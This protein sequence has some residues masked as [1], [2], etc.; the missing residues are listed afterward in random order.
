MLAVSTAV[1]E[2]E[3]AIAAHCLDEL[4]R[5]HRA[6]VLFLG[7]WECRLEVLVSLV[8]LPD[9]EGFDAASHLIARLAV[10]DGGV[11]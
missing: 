10:D 2:H 5:E 3:V 1:G 8:E 9:V 4:A 6:V 11:P 7:R